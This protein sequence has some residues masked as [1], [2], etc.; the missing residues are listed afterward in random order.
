MWESQAQVGGIPGRQP[1]NANK[2]EEMKRYR[3]ILKIR[4]FWHHKE[5][6]NMIT[7]ILTCDP[8]LET[9]SYQIPA[10]AGN[11]SALLIRQELHCNCSWKVSQ[12]SP[13]HVP[14]FCFVLSYISHPL[15]AFFILYFFPLLFSLVT[16]FQRDF[17]AHDSGL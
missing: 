4:I 2:R 15:S 14:F 17:F 12:Q 1:W 5:K 11:G 6:K 8:F 9:D 3:K 16:H 10:A 7:N 13:H